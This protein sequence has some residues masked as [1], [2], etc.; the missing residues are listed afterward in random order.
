MVLVSVGEEVT[1]ESSHALEDSK[2]RRV[3]ADDT[4]VSSGIVLCISQGRQ[5]STNQ[6][7]TH[8]GKGLYLES[9]IC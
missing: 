9:A 5:S 6:H 2:G 1:T 8:T 3:D 7:L 4:E